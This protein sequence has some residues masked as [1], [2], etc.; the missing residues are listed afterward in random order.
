MS[1]KEQPKEEDVLPDYNQVVEQHDS[2][3]TTPLLS[4]E[5]AQQESKPSEETI[6]SAPKAQTPPEYQLIEG[7]PE[8]T[9]NYTTGL[10]DCHK[11][12]GICL[13]ATCLPCCSFGSINATISAS[14]E[15]YP[16]PPEDESPSWVQKL[17]HSIPYSILV[18]TTP[19]FCLS[20]LGLWQR[21]LIRK[22]Y[23]LESSPGKDCLSHFCCHTCALAQDQREVQIREDRKRR[24][25]ALE[26]AVYSEQV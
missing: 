18:F 15:S 7:E 9:N 25:F 11:S 3:A 16:L 19:E 26:Q 23:D 14:A 5:K 12:P 1:M 6:E 4:E 10:F 21:L 13:S 8:L 2:A 17:V 20:S 22:Y 24:A